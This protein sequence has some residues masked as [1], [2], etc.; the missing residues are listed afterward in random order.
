[1]QGSHRASKGRHCK[2]ER[3]ATSEIQMPHGWHPDRCAGG[4]RQ[5]FRV[6]QWVGEQHCERDVEEVD[7]FHLQVTGAG[8]GRYMSEWG[9]TKGLA[10][11]R[12]MGTKRD[13]QSGQARDPSKFRRINHGL[14]AWNC[15]RQGPARL[16]VAYQRLYRS[17][18]ISCRSGWMAK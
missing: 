12:S 16:T 18:E 17:V 15:G 8:R 4:V 5:K 7:G 6:V 11:S 14:P 1:M 9:Q 13:G 3:W 2:V 10:C